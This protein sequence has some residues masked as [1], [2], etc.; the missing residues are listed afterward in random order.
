MV[1]YLTSDP[2]NNAEIDPVAQAYTNTQGLKCHFK[3]VG[4]VKNP[5]GP[6]KS[7][8]ASFNFAAGPLYFK[9]GRYFDQIQTD[10]FTAAPAGPGASMDKTIFPLW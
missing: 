5:W 1:K 10:Q 4:T 9:S 6:C 2:D 3:V 7:L 8:W